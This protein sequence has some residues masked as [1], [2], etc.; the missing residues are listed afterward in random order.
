MSCD[1][2]QYVH[3]IDSTPYGADYSNGKWL[4]NTI[5]SPYL[6]KERMTKIAFDDF[7]KH[8]GGR[9]DK[10]EGNNI[11]LSYVPINPDT[12]LLKRLKKQSNYDYLINIKGKVIYNDYKK[13]TTT[14]FLEIYDLNTLEIIYHRKVIGKHKVDYDDSRDVV[15]AKG[16]NGIIISSLK[17]IMRKIT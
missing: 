8:L 12:L 3:S 15:F 10:M 9:L 14:T 17:K 16:V 4:L 5:E 7:V 13:S 2:I 6:I 11:S 1:S